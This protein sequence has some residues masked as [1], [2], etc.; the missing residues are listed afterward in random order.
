MQLPECRFC[1]KQ[2][3]RWR[4]PNNPPWGL[5]PEPEFARVHEDTALLLWEFDGAPDEAYGTCDEHF[6]SELDEQGNIVVSAAGR[7]H[8][9]QLDRANGGLSRAER[10]RRRKVL[11]RTK[12]IAALGGTCPCGE[13]DP[14]L[15][16]I[17]WAFA[18]RPVDESGRT[19][20]DL[21]WH[22]WLMDNPKQRVHCH[23]E[24]VAHPVRLPDQHRDAAIQAYGGACGCGELENLRVVPNEGVSVP[25]YPGG[26]KM[27]SRDKYR[28]LVRQQFPAGW[29]VA[30][31][32]HSVRPL[33]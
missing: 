3:T 28:W 19:L 32:A 11:A 14:G 23:L 6:F 20:S 26:R 24:C 12:V 21:D 1:G 17:R 15:L 22:L 31:L 9:R 29:R 33:E 4:L 30:C 25:K 2:T 5:T 16:Q 10:V 27:G 13:S 18:T 8:Q 7:H